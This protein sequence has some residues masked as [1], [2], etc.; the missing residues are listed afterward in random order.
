VGFHDCLI[1][2]LNVECSDL[3]TIQR[4]PG[5]VPWNGIPL[6]SGEIVNQFYSFRNLEGD[7]FP[8]MDTNQRL[9]L[10]TPSSFETIFEKTT[11]DQGFISPVGNLCYYTDGTDAIKI[12]TI[13]SNLVS[14][15]GLAAPTVT[16]TVTGFGG[17]WQAGYN[18]PQFAAI[19][20]QNGNVEMALNGGVASSIEPKWSTTP[21]VE[22]PDGSNGLTWINLGPIQTWLPNT[23]YQQPAVVQDSNSN[24]QW[25][26][27]V[28][29]P[30]MPYDPGTTYNTGDTVAYAGQYFYSLQGSNTGNTPSDG[31]NLKISS[32]LSVPWW[33]LTT[34]PTATGTTVPDWATAFSGSEGA[35]LPPIQVT[36]VPTT[37]GQSPGGDWYISGPLGTN[38]H[39]SGSSAIQYESGLGFAIPS[40]AKILGVEVLFHGAGNSNSMAVALGTTYTPISQWKTITWAGGFSQSFTLGSPTDTWGVSLTPT[41]LNDPN[42]SFMFQFRS[43]P[44]VGDIY[45]NPDSIKVWY[46]EFAVDSRDTNDGSYTWVNIGPGTQLATANYDWRYAYRTAYG[47]LSTASPVSVSTGPILGPVIANVVGYSI[48]N[49]VATIWTTFNN[50]SVGQLV[51]IEGM[52]VGTYLNNTPLTITGG[53]STEVADVTDV[54]LDAGGLLTIDTSGGNGFKA[55][56]TVTFSNLQNATWLNGLTVIIGSIVGSPPNAFTATLNGFPAYGPNTDTGTAETNNAFTAEFDNP[57]VPF[58]IDQGT[59]E[60]AFGVIS[61][62]ATAEEQCNYTCPITAIEIDSNIL[63]VYAANRLTAGC[64]VELSGLGEGSPPSGADF[65]NSQQFTIIYASPTYF[66]AVYVPVPPLTVYPPTPDNGTATLMGVE[67]YR[68]LDGGG[69]WFYDG[70]VENPVVTPGNHYTLGPLDQVEVFDQVGNPPHCLDLIIDSGPTRQYDW[71][72]TGVPITFEGTGLVGVDGNTFSAA[73]LGVNFI[74]GSYYYQLQFAAGAAPDGGPSHMGSISTAAIPAPNWTFN[75]FTTD[76]NLNNLVPAP[77]NHQNDPFPN[78]KGSLITKPGTICSWYQGRHWV[79][80]GNTLQF[81]GGSDVLN[82]I[83]EESF[84]PANA[85]TFPGPVTGL[86][87]TTEGLVAMGADRWDAVLGGPQ[88]LSYYPDKIMD[89]FGIAQPNALDVDGN[90][91]IMLSTQ[92][93]FF[94][95]SVKSKDEIGHNIANL[96]STD[97]APP[98]SYVA[99]H[100]N[101]L[102]SGLFLSNGNNLVAR[103]GTNV[104]NWSPLYE[105]LMGAGAIRSVETSAG[106]YTLFL[107]P[108]TAGGMVFARDINVFADAG[109]PYDAFVTIGS[110]TVSE[111]GQPLVPLCHILT[112]MMNVGIPINDTQVS[113]LFNEIQAVPGAQFISIPDPVNEPP[114]GTDYS[115]S[116]LQYRWPVRMN[117][118]GHSMMVHHVQVRVDFGNTS[119]ARDELVAMSLKFDEEN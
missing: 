38:V 77:I 62:Q 69:I 109:Q 75:D 71:L 24:L 14:S 36:E 101:G 94:A 1:D 103:Y 57:D 64:T 46:T 12:D 79:A 35:A 114:I 53:T 32:G 3:F 80:C 2:G 45:L 107:A 66:Q 30:A 73:T 18:Y 47:H 11:T 16:P 49:N 21:G 104:Q 54:E 74:G 76:G 99:M 10:I 97:F 108:P 119:T 111:P 98:T 70:A 13:N 5:F 106:I 52:L 102:D 15:W 40:G 68:V 37:A 115:L 117:Q 59:V 96:V 84:P 19:Q 91:A 51:E 82:G 25:L 88:T 63:T 110:I 39:G 105:P 58:T 31:T 50:F 116:L 86:W 6:D 67:I 72:L 42:F 55:G 90:E 95:V 92:G 43:G 78:Q 33:S 118:D 113:V 61:G 44:G 34:A 9:A 81:D 27:S 4:R 8:L 23:Y 112:Y 41:D 48:T 26:F 17:F 7:V 56:Q 100:R 60:I 20:D 83:P 28:T 65:L 93:Q 29:N 22:S 87:P 85:F 89:K